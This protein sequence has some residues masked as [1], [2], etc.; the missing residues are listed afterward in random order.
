M[1]NAE[2]VD[3]FYAMD[4]FINNKVPLFSYIENNT[5]QDPFFQQVFKPLFFEKSR[6]FGRMVSIIPD[7]RKKPDKYTRI[8]GT[9]EPIN[10]MGLLI[11]NEAEKE[12]DHMKL[13]VSQLKS[14]SAMSKTMD[15]PDA[16]E[17]AVVKINE[18]ISTATGINTF[19]R[20]TNPKRY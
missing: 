1:K 5:L 16:L 17:G 18:R 12:T 11:F 9:L 20:P 4:V 2:F 13:L 7:G 10:R 3:C 6:Q 14:V 19:A 15:G 8:E